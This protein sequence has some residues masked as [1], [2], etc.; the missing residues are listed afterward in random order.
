[1]RHILLLAVLIFVTPSS[2]RATE[3]LI[4]DGGGYQISVVVGMAPEPVVASVRFTPPGAEE[5]I[6]VP[7]E[8]MQIKKFD[9]KKQVL[10]IRYVKGKGDDPALPPSFTFSANKK[11]AVLSIGDKRIKDSFSWLDDI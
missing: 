4:F 6:H 7:R 9:M 5:W 2:L 11:S 8:H 3:A 10:L 1:M